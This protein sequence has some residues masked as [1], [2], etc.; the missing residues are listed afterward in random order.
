M[1]KEYTDFDAMGLAELIRNG[2]VSKVEVL[3]AA[4]KQIGRSNP[5]IN[6]VILKMYDE[7]N[8]L[9]KQSDSNAP[10][11]GVPFLLKDLNTPYKG[12]LMQSGSKAFKDY[13]PDYDSNLVK[14]YKAAGLIV[15]G[16]TNTPEFGLKAVTEPEATGITKNPWN[17]DHTP[18]GSSGGSAAAVASG[19][20]PM[21]SA[22]DGGGSIRIPAS[23]CNLF[24]IKP[25]RGRVPTGPRVGDGWMGAVSQHVISR[26]V[27]DSALLLDLT[28]GA[29]KGS[30]IASPSN[31]ISFLDQLSKPVRKLRIGYS[32]LSPIDKG[33]DPQCQ[34]AID[35]AIK[36]LLELGHEVEE[37]K[38]PVDGRRMAESYLIMYFGEM[39]A[40]MDNLP[41]IIG[42]QPKK[43]DIELATRLLVALGKAT[44]SGEFVNAIHAW[45]FFARQM[46]DY[47]TRYD[48]FLT[49]TTAYP[50]PRIG[51]T[52]LSKPEEI[53][54]KAL[55]A[56][57]LLGLLKKTG[58]AMKI[59]FENLKFTPFTQL[60]NLTGLPAMSIPM[61]WTNNGLPLG[62]QFI[63]PFAGEAEMFQL[64]HQIE[65]SKPWD[66]IAKI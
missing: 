48:Y 56:F 63:G 25:S 5:K 60:A 21:A 58:V 7:A 42:H 49:P 66:K 31:D 40:L 23:H 15:L 6:A 32:A 29:E 1:F 8:R 36:L 47:Y 10:L 19:M 61:H 52:N 33:V 18:G 55:E 17:L 11:A 41:N 57:G 4:I 45:D 16:K 59:A 38:L 13:R 44:H 35:M 14:R 50:A 43:S 37:V 53:L 28:K 65:K 26:S 12:F 64:A 3:E 27:R 51:E 54:L 62:V 39:K 24:G 46:G 9:L 30:R 2:Q 20:V 22:G 34:Q